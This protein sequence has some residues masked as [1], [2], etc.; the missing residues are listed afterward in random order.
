L[1]TS[2]TTGRGHQSPHRTGPS[3]GRDLAKE[4]GST[5]RVRA[6]AGPRGA[7]SVRQVQG[8]HKRM[9]CSVLSPVARYGNEVPETF[10]KRVMRRAAKRATARHRL[11]TT[12]NVTSSKSC[13]GTC[14]SSTISDATVVPSAGERIRKL[15][16]FV[17]RAIRAPI[18][19]IEIT[20][21]AHA[22]CDASILRNKVGV[23]K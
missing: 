20:E 12:S 10:R 22:T 15:Q 8:W 5:V 23:R 21:G 14:R 13:S 19:D 18:V 4:P 17:C 11:L 7:G 6:Q 9:R 2:I 16:H 3:D 1:P